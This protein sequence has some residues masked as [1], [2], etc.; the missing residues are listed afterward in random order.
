TASEHLGTNL[1]FRPFKPQLKMDIWLLK[2]KMRPRS[3]LTDLFIETIQQ[4][5]EHDRLSVAPNWLFED[6]PTA[7]L[8]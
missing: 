6:T 8:R 2:P 1:V 7:G 4:A 3:R 5:V